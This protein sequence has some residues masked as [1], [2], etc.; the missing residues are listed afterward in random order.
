MAQLTTTHRLLAYVYEWTLD[1]E[2]K[3][4]SRMFGEFLTLRTSILWFLIV[5]FAGFCVEGGTTDL[6]MGGPGEQNFFQNNIEV[7]MV[8]KL[9]LSPIWH[10]KQSSRGKRK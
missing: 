4:K 9:T 10:F 7:S 6:A 2:L 8:I 1:Q 5:G 3:S